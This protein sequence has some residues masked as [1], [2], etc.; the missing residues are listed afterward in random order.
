VESTC[1]IYRPRDPRK[2]ALWGLLG[3]LYERV[4]GRWVDERA[5]EELFRHEVL[6][7]LRRRG[8][9]SQDRTAL[10]VPRAEASPP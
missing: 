1:R 9:L 4:K 10:L 5:A 2:A 6:T 3:A 7:L 8:P